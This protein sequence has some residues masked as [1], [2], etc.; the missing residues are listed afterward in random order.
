MV[1]CGRTVFGPSCSVALLFLTILLVPNCLWI[2]PI[3]YEKFVFGWERL[4]LF[5]FCRFICNASANGLLRLS[6]YGFGEGDLDLSFLPKR[7]D[8]RKRKDIACLIK[9]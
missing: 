7:L 2:V 5:S 8:A 6:G 4:A 9:S 3:F 1:C